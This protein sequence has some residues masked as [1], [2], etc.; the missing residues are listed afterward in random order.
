MASGTPHG[1]RQ[2]SDEPKATGEVMS[3][4]DKMKASADQAATKAKEGVQE[5]QTKRELSQ[6]YGELGKTAYELIQKGELSH[7]ELSQAAGQITEL[8]AR[9]DGSTTA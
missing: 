7:P 6:A 1:G 9:L 4:L 3:L 8:K 5:V 2:A